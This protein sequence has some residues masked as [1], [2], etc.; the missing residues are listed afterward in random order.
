MGLKQTLLS[1]IAAI[2]ENISRFA[3]EKDSDAMIKAATAA[4]V[5]E[6]ILKME[7]GYDTPVDV[8]G[9]SLSGGQIQRIALARALYG[10]PAL[11]VLD[12]PNANLDVEGDVAL[13]NAILKLREQKK[14]V[15]V[16]T[17]RPSVLESLDK[18]L[19]LNEGQQV[20]FRPREDVLDQSKDRKLSEPPKR[21]ASSRGPNQPFVVV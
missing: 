9:T 13:A 19:M 14:T 6:L 2:G 1:I 17:H 16:M 8:N 7:K 3:P 15:I 12:E 20:A 11:I 18:V 21:I 10:D 5:H 4:G